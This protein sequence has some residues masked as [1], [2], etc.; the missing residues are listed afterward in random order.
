MLHALRRHAIAEARRHALTAEAIYSATAPF[1]LTDGHGL[2][3]YQD[4]LAR[5]QAVA[6]P[7]AD[8][9]AALAAA[10]AASFDAHM[11][12]TDER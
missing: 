8:P 10:A 12:R 3:I 7:P 5:M 9:D 4:F 1:H 2:P 6:S 11:R